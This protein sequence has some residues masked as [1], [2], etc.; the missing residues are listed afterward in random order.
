MAKSAPG[1]AICP[2]ASQIHWTRLLK[3]MNDLSKRSGK[4]AILNIEKRHLKG[5][6]AE[7]RRSRRKRRKI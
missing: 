5:S 4:Q 7:N 3:D 2:T 6:N 1:H